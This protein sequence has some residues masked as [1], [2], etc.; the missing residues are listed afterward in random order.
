VAVS[1]CRAIIWLGNSPLKLVEAPVR[2]VLSDF[3][4]SLV[5]VVS[6]LPPD[7]AEELLD[8]I[9]LPMRELLV[10]PARLAGL[11]TGSF[12]SVAAGV[13]CVLTELPVRRPTPFRKLALR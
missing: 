8:R 10:E 2:E 5:P 4:V 7:K 13:S 1:F 3:R 11:A 9:E 12:T 6:P